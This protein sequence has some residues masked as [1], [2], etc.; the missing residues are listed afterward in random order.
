[1]QALKGA[2]DV[3]ALWGV[4]TAHRTCFNQLHYACL[5]NRLAKLAPSGSASTRQPA[6]PPAAGQ[7]LPQL[8]AACDEALAAGA[9]GYQAWELCNVVWAWGRLDYHPDPRAWSAVHA[10]LFGPPAAAVQHQ[11]H[12][13]AVGRPTHG[14]GAGGQAG[15]AQG[16]VLLECNPH[17]LSNLAWGLFKLQHAAAPDW[18]ALAD[19]LQRKAAECNAIDLSSVA[20]AFAAAAQYRMA[21]FGALA[22][23]AVRRIDDFT[24]QDLANMLWAYASAGHEYGPLFSAAARAVL[25][26]LPGFTHKGLVQVRCLPVVPQQHA[27][28]ATALVP[29]GLCGF[30]HRHPHACVSSVRCCGKDASTSRVR[31]A[32]SRPQYG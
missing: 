6:S 19:A 2:R 28:T 16:T 8:L 23:A 31:H 17:S 14:R 21:L 13:D 12:P 18:D 26:T 30:L 24:P 3:A 10:V 4:F 15:S 7:H 25:R 27:G 1:M 22:Q 9:P 32:P 5:L 20:Y 11:D 29:V